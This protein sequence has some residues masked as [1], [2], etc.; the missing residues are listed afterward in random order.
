MKYVEFNLSHLNQVV[1]LLNLCFPKNNVT[2]NSFLWKHFSHFF[3]DKSIGMIAI[4]KKEVCAF[5]CFVPI[6]ISNNNIFLN[7]FYL[8]AIQC[9]HP[10]YRR[11]GI[12]SDLTKI[13]ENKLGNNIEYIGFSN[14]S[15]IKIDKF[16]KKINYQ[17][18]GQFKKK[19]IPSFPYRKTYKIEQIYNIPKKIN[20]NST[21]FGILKNI[22]YLKWRYEDNPKNKY[23]YFKVLNNSEII[24]Y[25]I[26]KKRKVGY[27]MF[28]LILHNY[29]KNIYNL[30]IKS[31]AKFSLS[32]GVPLTYY[33]FLPNVFFNKCFSNILSFSKKIPIFLTI[34]SNN[35]N[36]KN[37]EN[38]ILQKGDII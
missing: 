20:Y 24:G 21:Y 36:L 22:N 35:N 3:D 11:R 4:D 9:T 33:E 13:I 16:S 25:I 23:K 38:W 2:N 28:D 5:V 1:N 8:C 6:I 18:I 32:K 34:K 15:G 27:E 17:I 30:T 37:I 26:C 12:I 14:R 31:F 7:N 10:N 29:D 19:I